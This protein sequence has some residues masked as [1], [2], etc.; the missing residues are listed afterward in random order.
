[1]I[2][3]MKSAL[4]R[5]YV[6]AIGTGWLLAQGIY[7]VAM[8]LTMPLTLWMQQR[9]Q[10]QRFLSL[11]VLV[12]PEP[13]PVPRFPYEMAVPQLLSAVLL[14]LAAWGLLR[15]LYWSGEEETSPAKEEPQE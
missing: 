10:Q 8:V 15:W 14:L 13:L 2:E 12:R 11:S 7:H 1:M 4:V 9:S 3:R 6:G 5:S